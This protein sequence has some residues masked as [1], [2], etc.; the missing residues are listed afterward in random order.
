MVHDIT[1]LNFPSYATLTHAEVKH[2]DMGEKNI[3]TQI[4]INGDIT[5]DFSP[6]WEVEFLGE[7]Y[8]MP[9]RQPQGAKENTSLNSTI[10]LTFQ[11]W[12]IY[13]LKRW[14]FFTVQPVETGT[15]VADKYIAD[16]ILNLGDFCNLFGQVLRHYYGDTITIDLNPNWDYKQEAVPISISHSYIWDVLIKLYEL[17]AVRWSIG[18]NGDSSHYVIKVGYPTE[19]LD[20]IFEY[21]FEG[22][23]LK[24]ERQVQNEDIRNMILGR[25][26]E[27][28]LPLR[29]FKDVD[30]DNPDFRGDPDW[31][32]ELANI[33]FTNLRGATFRSYIQGWK[34]A[35]IAKYSGYKAVGE[36]NAYAPWAY[37][38]GYTDSKFDPV[39]YVKDDE[40]IA[41]Y[42]PLL[43]GLDNNED[44]Y[45]SIQGTGMDVAV[46]V[47]QI[48]SDDVA[49]STEN[50]AKEEDKI[51]ASINVKAQPGHGTATRSSNYTYFTVPNGKTANIKGH[52]GVKAF[53]P[54]DLADM[55]HLITELD[56]TI[57][58]FNATTG[59]ER[60]ASGIPAGSWYFTVDFAFNNTTDEVLNVT[61]SFN[62]IKI[63]SATPSDK[64]L[65]TFD[66]WVK[67]IWETSKL[68]TET[69][70]EYAERIWKPILG[71][72]EQNTAKVMFTTGALAISEDYEFTIVDFPKL[73]TSKSL[74][75]ERSHWRIKLA[76]SEADLES[77]GLYVP[78]TKRQGKAGDKFIFIGTEMT[79]HYV[80]WAE[81]TLDD[82]KK[83]QLREKKDI[84]PT[85]AVTTDRVRLN[86]EGK[87]N[88]LIQKLRIGNSLR[89]A[90]KRF[91]DGDYETLY[92]QSL[93]YTYHE[94]SG[95]DTAL[96]PDVAIVLSN[97]YATTA[98]PVATMQGDI[99]A[100]Q[101]QVGSISNVEQIV[102][103][104]GDKLYLRKNGKS[105]RSLSPTQ[106]LS[107]LT[108]GDFRAGL[109]GGAGWGFYKDENSNWV[110][111]T[112]R[113]NVR[114]EMQ[115]NTLVINQAEG[116]GGMEI[117]TAAYIKGVTRVAET[118][119][120]Y[121]C[122]FDQKGGSVANLFHVDDVAYCNRWTPENA[123][124]KFY[125]RRVTAVDVD[126]ITLTKPLSEAQRPINWPD[127][128]VNGTGIPAEGDNV[129]HFGNYTDKTRQYV[130]VRDVVGGGYERYIEELNSVNAEGVEYYFVGKQAGQSRWFVGN[131]DLVPYSGAGD[132]SYIEYINRR[133]NLNN[134]TLSVNTTIG[135]K[136]IEEYIKE[137][138]PPVEQED[139]EDFVNAIVNPKIEGIQDQID[140][141]IETWFGN[142]EPTLSNYPAS[143]W[144]TEALKIQHLGD[145]YYD[146]DTGTAYRF[147]QKE[148][149][150]YYWN[151]I[152][153]DAIT[154]ALAAAKAAQDTADGKRRIFTSQ[155]TP[156]YDKGDLWVNATYPSGTTSS[157][158][159]P[160][161]GKYCNDILR[162]GT[163][164]ATGSF[165]IGDWGLSSNYTDDTAANKALDEIAGYRYLKGALA[166]RSTTIGGLFLTSLIR[167]GQNNESLQT[168]TV[169]SGL[170][171]VYTKP[172][173]LSY[174][175][176][177]DALDLFNDDDT[178]KTLSAGSR[179][180]AA[181]V[182]MDGSSYFAKG[183]IGFRADGSGWLGNDLTGIKFSNTGSMTFG[184]GVKINL[185]D[186]SE[187]GIASTL[188]SILNFNTG[189][190]NLLMP[191]DSDGLEIPW[192]EATQSDGAGGIKAKSLK[193]KLGLWSP[194]FLT[195]RG[196]AS[197]ISGGGAGASALSDLNDVLLS[198]SLSSGNLL[199]YDGTHWVNVSQSSL[200]PDLSGYATVAAL[201]AHATDT[202]IHVT[203]T[204]R[205]KW[206][207]TASDLSS[208]L[209]SD[210]D[211][212]INKWD[213]VVAFLDTYTEADTL[214]NL[215]SNKADKSIS[216]KAGTGLTGGGTLAADRTLSLAASGVTAGTYPKVAVD[217]YGRVTS[218]TS[219]AASDIPAL[220]IS[221]ISGLQNTLNTK[222]DKSVFNDLFEKV[223][224]GTADA[225][226]YAI[227]AKYGL[228]TEEFLTGRGRSASI[229][230]GG[231]GES[232]DRLDSW[233]D[234]TPDK[235]GYVLSAGLGWDLNTRVK[236]LEAGSA[237]SFVTS[238][239]GNV[240]TGIAKSGNVVTITKGLEAATAQ[241]LLG[242]VTIATAQTI[243]GAK[244][245]SSKLEANAGV[246]INGSTSSFAALPY[247]MLHV[248]NVRYSKLVMNTTDGALH[249]LD[250]GATSFANY[251]SLVASSFVK[252]GGT[253][254]QLLV[255]NG[256]TKNVADFFLRGA[257]NAVRVDKSVASLGIAADANAWN[258]PANS[259]LLI[260][261]YNNALSIF[262]GGIQNE[263][264]VSIQAGH[265]NIAYA[266]AVGTLHLNK[267]GGPVYINNSLALTAANAF[268]NFSLENSTLTATVGAVTRT[269][270]AV[271][272]KPTGGFSSMNAVA[273]L[274]NCIG[275]TSLSGTDPT[276]N[277]SAQTGWHHFINI[278][279]NSEPG[280]MWQTQIA[281]MAGTT[282]L[283]VR[284]RAGNSIVNG[285]AWK[286]PW[287][288]ILTQGV[289]TIDASTLD[290]NTWYPVVIPMD[291]A[292]GAYKFQIV[293]TLNGG[294]PS[295]AT[296]SRGFSTRKVWTTTGNGYGQLFV[297]RQ[298]IDSQFDWS[299]LDPVRGIGQMGRSSHEYVY[300]R[301]GGKY[302]FNTNNGTAPRL[303]TESY[304]NNGETVAPTT[305]PPQ[306][307][308][309]TVAMITDNVA[310]ANKWATP[311]KLWGQ[312]VDG[313]SDVNGNM[314]IVGAVHSSVGIST[315]GYLTGKGQASTS[316]ARL[317]RHVED[318][319]FTVDQIAAAPL[320]RF[321]WKHDGSIDVGS[322][323][324]YWHAIMPELTH[325]LP[326]AYL[327]LDYGKAALL[328]SVSLARAHRN[329]E[330]R[331]AELERE[332]KKLKCLIN[333]LK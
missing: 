272:A 247:I 18:P 234:Y 79:H 25:G 156:P 57:K 135:D 136:S 112:D 276:D 306:A 90:D 34:A 145:L 43:G 190:S 274:G 87:A 233:A 129:I 105:D 289:Y 257:E 13:Q 280:N 332:N 204:D 77:T 111:E 181:A 47:E 101:R 188:E 286:A 161:K 69:N 301:G 176:G 144:N 147:S 305:T 93:T 221:K 17:F 248:P 179:P 173:D 315:D 244:T 41:Q 38:K 61:C 197:N 193:A 99:S 189:L 228:Y 201:T 206:D 324:Q 256:E 19:E 149:K 285:A 310:S 205:A 60:S 223:N 103:A 251:R 192:S 267:L 245:F 44:I 115:V 231:G 287:A 9:L 237:L 281:N 172:R 312:Y 227:R 295:W 155:P 6:D 322:T 40:S 84:K 168:Q 123:E 330:G 14:M 2:D 119:D 83:D 264:V 232:Y 187:E 48:E 255:A 266:K 56:Y 164:R 138:S 37:R 307:I 167:L 102:R 242:Y 71:D 22:G 209:G 67:N 23:L 246:Q 303:L 261:N 292:R 11:H 74:N 217:A 300:V 126:S 72:R 317:K 296:H 58:V 196:Q 94:P 200:K 30:T 81:T 184:N 325:V 208:I 114:Q 150:T 241:S 263:R 35:H 314:T 80:V 62:S 226:K 131:K 143:G 329:L 27:K 10:D 141:V 95:D 298:I 265:N 24:V 210:S 180:A 31:V 185:S 52:A 117:D 82:W 240:V 293:V 104:V 230:G 211:T 97:D 219:L 132:G 70:E 229:S 91:I 32:E 125:K 271:S 326:D 302:H 142:G 163:S 4:K 159:D 108:S 328:A 146:N 182:R 120:G 170:N 65:N 304:T 33:Y 273:A 151:T 26:G 162:C 277:P 250:G 169:W 178:R 140:G 157:T 316:D 15:A 55:S 76:K 86:N 253:Y 195:A 278:S 148:D 85:W 202:D 203:T 269:V 42:G 212:I 259:T 191:C 29:Y 36:S 73:D 133:F 320:W 137:V 88:A 321:A 225:P 318:V 8:I 3:T 166:D 92:L 127:S 107:L 327:G 183:N 284:S 249:L 215:L 100:L 165:A 45:P 239:S 63:E 171:G 214:A 106:F 134:V 311:R 113:V 268:T 309:R 282:D 218:G 96:N 291:P 89:L 174:W 64:W 7:K 297:T 116:R 275:M 51:F 319:A 50:D 98:N 308:V 333:L 294:V 283:W 53:R 252:S 279:Y 49:E 28:N 66:I 235:T 5:P 1:E 121:V 153:D 213:E 46:A 16:V 128:G 258:L 236:S 186:G 290:P 323:A 207:K 254:T 68:S 177:G 12:A 199:Q 78:S 198:A 110:L 130:K 220:D 39:E 313:T 122:Y 270:N 299:E 158:R 59:A 216:I 331:V 124:L 224:I 75:G 21:G 152:T 139:I 243:S 160:A 109:I 154:K 262:V 260:S 288:R 20:H 194:A 222:L 238:G 118:S 175:A 54:E